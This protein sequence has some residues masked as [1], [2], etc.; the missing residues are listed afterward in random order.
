MLPHESHSLGLCD[1]DFGHVAHGKF[2][3]S[4]R[5]WR[6]HRWCNS[7][8]KYGFLTRNSQVWRFMIHVIYANNLDTCTL[9]TC[10]WLHSFGIFGR[11][12]HSEQRLMTYEDLR[13]SHSW[14]MVQERFSCV[15]SFVVCILKQSQ[16]HR[17]F[18]WLKCTIHHTDQVNPNVP[19]PHQKCFIELFRF[20]RSTLFPPPSLDPST[21]ASLLLREQDPLAC[22]ASALLPND[23]KQTIRNMFTIKHS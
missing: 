3:W 20:E 12:S 11:C 15:K 14:N 18:S 21:E 5:I 6:V 7:N 10:D 23:R 19:Q 2:Q 16:L 1:C 4:Y 22:F 17:D 8:K 13:A 9:Y